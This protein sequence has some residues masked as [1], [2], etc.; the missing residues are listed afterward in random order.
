MFFQTGYERI[1]VSANGDF[2]HLCELNRWDKW[3]MEKSVSV[4]LLC[5]N[6]KERDSFRCSNTRE[7]RK[8]VFL[9]FMSDVQAS[10]PF[11]FCK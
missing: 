11:F 3:I 6:R 10:M 8:F 1:L 5:Y 9:S 7:R 2:V 4:Q